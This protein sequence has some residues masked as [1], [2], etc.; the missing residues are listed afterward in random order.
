MA[1][2]DSRQFDLNIERV[3]EHWTVPHAVR[4]VLANALDEQALTGTLDPAITRAP[5]GTW[6]I[7]DYGRGIRYQ[8]LTQKENTEKL[9]RS[10][11]VIGKFGVGLKDAF[12]TF[13]RHGIGVE[14]RSRH[15]R[16]TIGKVP[17]HGFE[18]L[19]TLHAL[20]SESRDPTF[21]GTDFALG[22]VTDE[23]IE[24][25]KSFFLRWS[26]DEVLE[27]TPFWCSAAG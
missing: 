20:I 19:R 23:N 25:A 21:E 9:K 13:D 11:D 24:M 18:D 26:E 14:I 6:H 22:G 17:K 8:H 15:G 16:I 4:E 10:D 2:D 27:T 12:A 3:L 7:R 1:E 5:D